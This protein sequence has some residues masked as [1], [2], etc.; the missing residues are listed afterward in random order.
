MYNLAIVKYNIIIFS[1]KI[2][3]VQFIILTKQDVY[4]IWINFNKHFKLHSMVLK[5][6]KRIL[7]HII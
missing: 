2:Q 5:L 1:K 3:L 6:M 7:K 4:I